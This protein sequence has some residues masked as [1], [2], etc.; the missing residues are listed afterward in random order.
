M[1]TV[2]NFRKTER[3]QNEGSNIQSVLDVV[4]P[5]EQ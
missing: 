4:N 2:G 1:K 5:A 3:R